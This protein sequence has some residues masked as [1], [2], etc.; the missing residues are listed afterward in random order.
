MLGEFLNWIGRQDPATVFYG[1][2]AFL[3]IC[4]AHSYR[5]IGR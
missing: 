5:V 2:A 3:F 1:W 4:T